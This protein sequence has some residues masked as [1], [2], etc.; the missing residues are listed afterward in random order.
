[1]GESVGVGVLVTP[2]VGVPVVVALEEGVPVVVAPG[3]GVPVVVAPG[4]GVPVAVALGTAVGEA[5]GVVC[6]SAAPPL[7]DCAAVQRKALTLIVIES[8]VSEPADP[9]AN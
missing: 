7:Y 1:V 6:G 4:V 5:V 9:A 2:G 3:E 8:V